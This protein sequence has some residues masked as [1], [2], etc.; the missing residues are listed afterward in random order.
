MIHQPHSFI[1]METTMT[2]EAEQIPLFPDEQVPEGQ[3]ALFEIDDEGH[4]LFAA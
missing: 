3:L 2:A 4:F 1:P